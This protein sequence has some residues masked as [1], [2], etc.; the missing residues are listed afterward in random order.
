MFLPTKNVSSKITMIQIRSRNC[1][2]CSKSYFYLNEN[3]VEAET[4]GLILASDDKK[5]EDIVEDRLM[6]KMKNCL[7]EPNMDSFCPYCLKQPPEYSFKR[8]INLVIVSL[9]LGIILG[10]GLA[11]WIIP[12]TGLNTNNIIY[13][14]IYSALAVSVI[15]YFLGNVL[16]KP[17]MLKN[18]SNLTIK[19]SMKISEMQEWVHNH[20]N[21]VV[22]WYYENTITGAEPDQQ[23]KIIFD[24]GLD[25]PSLI[26][27]KIP[28]TE[29]LMKKIEQTGIKSLIYNKSYLGL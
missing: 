16:S 20:D 25:N 26:E 23:F 22:D 10:G 11:A 9:L 14:M 21:P 4:T 7:S 29:S 5:L 12:F 18:N 8:Q 2:S 15:C 28:S 19:G 13:Y 24:L 17:E 1:R 3:E 27:N 6:A